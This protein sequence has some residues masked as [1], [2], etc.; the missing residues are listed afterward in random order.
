MIETVTFKCVS[1]YND[2]YTHVVTDQRHPHVM[3]FI[4]SWKIYK[5]EM[6]K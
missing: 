3:A 5:Q 6:I 4:S 2:P 1:I